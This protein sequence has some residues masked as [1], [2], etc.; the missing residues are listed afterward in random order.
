[1]IQRGKYDS[2]RKVWFVWE[3]S[4]KSSARKPFQMRKWKGL[5]FYALF[6]L[7]NAPNS[8]GSDFL[9]LQLQHNIDLEQYNRLTRKIREDLDKLK[10]KKK[11]Y[12]IQLHKIENSPHSKRNDDILCQLKNLLNLKKPSRE[13]LVN[14]IDQILISKDKTI[15]IK[16]KFKLP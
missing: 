11:E 16:Y 12:E 9:C 3:L 14:L 13:L 1:M 6:R 4:K 8:V 7:G 5:D 15:E 10:F 2:E